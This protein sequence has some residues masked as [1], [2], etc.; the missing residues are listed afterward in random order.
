MSKVSLSAMEFEPKVC[1]F[2][3]RTELAAARVGGT[4]SLDVMA[5]IPR[6]VFP[7][8]LF[9]VTARGAG[10]ISIYQ[11]DDDRL[12]FLALFAEAVRRHDWVCHAFCLMTNHYHLVIDATREHLSNGLQLLNGR[13]AQGFN[14]KHKRWGH[15]F[16]ERFWCGSLEE[17]ELQRTC[18]YVMANPVRAGL[19]A[20]ISDWPWSACRYDLD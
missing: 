20:R 19:C 2:V 12:V 14:A 7:D 13:Y 3:H 18:L 1:R 15:L 10:Q 16:G 6:Y 5:R 4:R 17:E 8:G 11:D 9:H